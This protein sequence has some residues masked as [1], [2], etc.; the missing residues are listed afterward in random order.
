MAVEMI[1]LRIAREIREEREALA[2]HVPPTSP[3]KA[4]MTQTPVVKPEKSYTVL[5]VIALLI[6]SV[7]LAV[8]SIGVPS[9]AP[10]AIVSGLAAVTFAVLS[11]REL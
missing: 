4:P 1:A 6:L 5:L 8:V 2:Q 11:L 3:K 10:V 9:L 7:F